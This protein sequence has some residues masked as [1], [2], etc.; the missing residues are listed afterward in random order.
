MHVHQAMVNVVGND[1]QNAQI[2]LKTGI[3]ASVEQSAVT[4]SRKND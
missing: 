2:M 1:L 4:W 3:G